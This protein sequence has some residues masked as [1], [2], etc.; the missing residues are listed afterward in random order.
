M[1][2]GGRSIEPSAKRAHELGWG[3][4]ESS[5]RR[6]LAVECSDAPREV[7]ELALVHL[8]SDCV[9]VAY[10]RSDLFERHRELMADWVAHR[11]TSR[12]AA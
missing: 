9:E 10:R 3:F 7:C 1:D 5:P 6:D 11:A 2:G 12:F 8:Y 4:N